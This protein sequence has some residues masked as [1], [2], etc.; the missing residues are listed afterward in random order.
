MLINSPLI[1]GKQLPV[2]SNIDQLEAA[3]SE[4]QQRL[5][6]MHSAGRFAAKH[7]G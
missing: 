2:R 6:T 4:K 7:I 5:P 1:V 3:I